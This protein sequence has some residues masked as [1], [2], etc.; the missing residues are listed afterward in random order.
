MLSG[1][2]RRMGDCMKFQG[3][4]SL[5]RKKWFYFMNSRLLPSKHVSTVYRDRAVLLY[6]IL[7]KFKFCVGN[8]IKNSLLEG[9]AGKSLIHP[10]L[11]TQ[12]SRDAQVVIESDEERSPSMAPL[13][14]PI[15]K[16]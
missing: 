9:D 10:S 12:L 13:T 16:P 2:Q 5:S 7:M 3:D 8:I 1:A 11:I 14:F 4:A 6:A 15:E